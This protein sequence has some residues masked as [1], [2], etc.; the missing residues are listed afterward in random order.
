MARYFLVYTKKSKKKHVGEVVTYD[1]EGVIGIFHK[2]APLTKELKPNMLVIARILSPKSKT[3]NFYILYPE[4]ILEG[5]KIPKKYDKDLIVWGR[6]AY[7]ELRRRKILARKM[8]VRRM[9]KEIDKDVK[10]LKEI[11]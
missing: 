11:E 3:R 2:K 8:E 5:Y 9:L 7:K 4:Y 6:P 10:E 1:S